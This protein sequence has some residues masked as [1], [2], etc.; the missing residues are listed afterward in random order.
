MSKN[1]KKAEK[2]NQYVQCVL[3]EQL[4]QPKKPQQGASV[5]TQL[6]EGMELLDA[7]DGSVII[8]DK[9]VILKNGIIQK[10]FNAITTDQQ[11]SLLI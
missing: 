9:E 6:H 8:G 1:T 2:Y 7:T 11:L 10:V 4:E 5:Y 3:F